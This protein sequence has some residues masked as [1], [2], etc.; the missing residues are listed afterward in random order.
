MDLYK[1][2]GESDTLVAD[3]EELEE[4]DA[5]ELHARRLN[6]KEVLTPMDGGKFKFPIADGTVKLSGGDQVVRTSTL[7][8]TEER[9]KIIFEEN[10]K[11]QENQT[12]L[13]QPLFKTHRCMPVKP[14]MISGPCQ[15]ILFTFITL[16]RE[17]NCTCREKHYIPHLEKV[18]SNVRQ[19]YRL[20]PGDNMEHLDV[21]AAIWGI[22]VSVFE[23]QFILGKIFR[24]TRNQPMK[25][26]KQLFQVTGKLIR[27]QAEITSIPVIYWQHQMWQRTTLLTDKAVQFGN[28]KTCLFRFSAVSGRNEFRSRRSLEGQDYMVY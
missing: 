1:T 7:T 21:S 17:S 22:F 23:L 27:D 16:N 2:W 8:R 3:I 26:L 13:L 12:G 19:R 9:N 25:S 20:G 18:F 24:S 28:A 4:M 6:A 11:G 15:A 5:S 10:Q 14:N